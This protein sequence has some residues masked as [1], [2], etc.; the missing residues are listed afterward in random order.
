[1]TLYGSVTRNG[2]N[3]VAYLLSPE[4]EVEKSDEV[5]G[6]KS[7]K[8]KAEYT[9]GLADEDGRDRTTFTHETQHLTPQ[10]T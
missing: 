2:M 7:K 5:C 6:S 8:N 4:P 3:Y 1:M 9:A 10:L